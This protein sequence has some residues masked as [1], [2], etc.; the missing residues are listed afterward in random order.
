M[1]LFHLVCSGL[2]SVGCFQPAQE[3]LVIGFG[4]CFKFCPPELPEEVV[5]L[6]EEPVCAEPAVLQERGSVCVYP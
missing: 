6:P 2:Q 4:N 3:L 1:W 5:C